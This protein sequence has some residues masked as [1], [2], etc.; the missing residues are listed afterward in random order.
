M[1]RRVSEHEQPCD[2]WLC[3]DGVP[4]DLAER[5]KNAKPLGQRMNLEEALEWI[6]SIGKDDPQ[7]PEQPPC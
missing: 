2:C 6:G 7:R 4:D 5:I 3:R 1:L